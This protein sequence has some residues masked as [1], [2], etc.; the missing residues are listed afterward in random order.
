MEWL[1]RYFPLVTIDF[2]QGQGVETYGGD[3]LRHGFVEDHMLALAAQIKAVNSSTTVLYYNNVDAALPFYRMAR[4][5]YERHPDWALRGVVT[6][7]GHM[8]PNVSGLKFNQSVPAVHDLWMQHYANMTR[9]S[10]PLDG[11]FVDVAQHSNDEA[12]TR[13]LFEAM[14]QS[15]PGLIRF[16]E[17]TTFRG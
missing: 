13:A 2:C 12:T 3:I 5:L 11:I 9:P 10:S 14:Q 6:D 1:A 16:V 15:N 17:E 4:P 8:F 7:G